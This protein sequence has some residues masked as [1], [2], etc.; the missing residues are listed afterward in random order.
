MRGVLGFEE[1]P[2][3]ARP[4]GGGH[5]Q[6]LHTHWAQ[7]VR[8]W[9]EQCLLGGLGHREDVREGAFALP[10]GMA[11]VHRRQCDGGD[12]AQRQPR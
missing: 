1:V 9:P 6:G 10:A 8:Q 3:D 7:A 12:H 5:V 4:S 2:A 11:G